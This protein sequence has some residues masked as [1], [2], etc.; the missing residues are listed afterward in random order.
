MIRLPRIKRRQLKYPWLPSWADIRKESVVHPHVEQECAHLF[1]AFNTGTTELEVL[2]WLH[3]TIMALKPRLVLETGAANGLGTIAL[4][5]ACRANGFG[6]VHSVELDGSLCDALASKLAAQHLREYVDIHCSDSRD[7]LRK[8]ER[9]F[10]IGFF[11]SMCEI[12]A[13]EFRICLDRGTVQQLAMF[14]DTSPIRCESL[15][16]WPSDEQHA[17]YREQLREFAS[18]PRCSGMFESTLSRGFVCL[19]LR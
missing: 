15:K 3:A 2:N 7:F 13:E 18:H 10:D 17:E 5:S 11:D 14:H 6:K 8:N 1:D 9:V 12:R 4:A 16:G 19:F